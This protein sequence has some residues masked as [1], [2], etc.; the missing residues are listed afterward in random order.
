MLLAD[1]FENFRTMSLNYYK[2]DPA[3]YVTAPGFSWDAMLL[4]TN[5][6]LELVNNLEIYP[7]LEKGVRGGLAQ[8]TLRHATPNNKYL[9]DFD[10]SRPTSYLIYLDCNNLYGFAMMKKMPISDFRFLTSTEITHLNIE[11]INDDS[12]NEYIL[13]V[14]LE[15]PYHLH[16]MHCDLPFA[17]EKLIPPGGKSEKLVANLYNKTKYIIHYVHLK[18]CLKQ[19]LKLTKVHRVITFKQESFLKKY[20]DLNTR[21]RQNSKSDFEKDFFKLLNNSIFGKTIENKRKQVNVKLVSHW[22]DNNNVTKKRLGARKLIA[23]PNLKSV[24]VFS[25]NLLAIQLNLEKIALDRPIYVGFTVLEYAKQHLYQ[26]HY[27]FIKQKYGNNA[28]LC[29]TD[30]DSLLY[31]INTENVYQD[32]KDNIQEFDTSNF[33]KNNLYGIPIVNNKIPGLFKDEMG[34]ELITEF[35]GLRAKLYCIKTEKD[36]IKKA[37]GVSKSVVKSLKIKNYLDCLLDDKDLKCKMNKIK[38]LKHALYSQQVNK[39]VLNRN[40]DKHRILSNQIDTVA[41]GHYTYE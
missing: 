33:D 20:I 1:I 2:L 13:E 15:Y 34:G 11:T 40:D 38:S 16:D 28:K 5:V 6:K 24:S 30:T 4:Y 22:E 18:E 7:M 8:C 9:S 14:D 3:Y 39:L 19:G 26:F 10:C 27:N 36:E 37:K 17:V 29:Y 25:E 41:W 35:I 23:K 31:L 32:I 21:L 12:D